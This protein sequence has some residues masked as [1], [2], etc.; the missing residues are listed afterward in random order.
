MTCLCLDFFD[1]KFILGTKSGEIVT[2]KTK[3]KLVKT[4]VI[5]EQNELKRKS[6][7]KKTYK[8]HEAKITNIVNC[9]SEEIFISGSQDGKI[10]F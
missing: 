5:T 2:Y 9:I 3:R 1:K 8:E 10:V 6:E 4:Y 7:Y